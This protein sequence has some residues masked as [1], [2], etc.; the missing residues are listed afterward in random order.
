MIE[1]EMLFKDWLSLT[2]GNTDVLQNLQA[3]FVLEETYIK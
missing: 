1:Y 2:K 3:C